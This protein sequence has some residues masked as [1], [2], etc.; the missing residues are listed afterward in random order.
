MEKFNWDTLFCE[1]GTSWG[2]EPSDSALLIANVFQ[3]EQLMRVLIPGVGYGRNAIPFMNAGLKVKG[4]EISQEAIALA[5]DN[6]INFPIQQGSVIDMPFD[7]ERVDGIFCYCLLHL[8]E[9]LQRKQILEACYQQ[10]ANDGM[11]YFV[12]VSTQAD[13]YSQGTCIGPDFYLLENGLSVFFYNE[14][15]IE[16]D[17]SDFGLVEY[18]PFEEPIKHLPS[19]VPLK[20]FLVKCV[21]H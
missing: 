20:C 1:N 14:R 19:S 6:G 9:P 3:K 15:S 4:I 18:R 5:R 10:L 13:M 16:Q 11:M 8:F 12:V 2:M 7:S 21:K 17:F